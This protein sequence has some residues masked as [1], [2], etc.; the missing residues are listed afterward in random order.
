MFLTEYISC[1]YVDSK[2]N[3]F[4]YLYFINKLFIYSALF[5]NSSKYAY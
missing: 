1:Q 4:F 3:V 5:D 2:I